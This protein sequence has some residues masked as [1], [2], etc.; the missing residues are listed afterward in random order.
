MTKGAR[1]LWLTLLIC[2]CSPPEAK[3][4]KEAR[5]QASLSHP[6][7]ALESFDRVMKRNP[8]GTYA[9]RAAREGA[10][11]STLELKD[12]KRAVN[13][14]QFLVLHS[15]DAKERLNSQR[16]I[17]TLYFDQLQDYDK[18]NIEFNKLIAE[19]ESD[20]DIARY[21][22][23]ISRANYYQGNFFQAHSEIDD[24]L[25]L[26]VDDDIRFSALVLKSNIHIAQ[27]EYSKAIDI[28]KKLMATY[29]QKA[30]QE[31]VPQTLAVCYE[32]SGNFAEAIKILESVKATHPRP[33][34]IEIRIK[35]L[36]ERQR[37]QPG[38]KGLRK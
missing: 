8:E 10:R 21:K 11:I 28:L 23:D 37:N 36:K 4:Y 2:A 13:Y 16:Q 35:R 20:Q 18:A 6:K 26:K 12:Y 34:Y 15:E 27:K 1:I 38:A 19:T 14:Y 22:L 3:D 25:K 5:K 30:V 32:E 31:N 7:E 9:I 29:P 17:A 33:D 24:V